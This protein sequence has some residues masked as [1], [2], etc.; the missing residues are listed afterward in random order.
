MEDSKWN[1][2]DARFVKSGSIGTRTVLIDAA[3]NL[4]LTTPKVRIT[5]N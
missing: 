4:I 5:R 1:G 2:K 3:A